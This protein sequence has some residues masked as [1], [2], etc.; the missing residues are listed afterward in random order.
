MVKALG[1]RDL[2]GKLVLPRLLY[3]VV[4]HAADRTARRS[5]SFLALRPARRISEFFRTLH[6]YR[7]NSEITFAGA[8]ALGALL[9]A[10]AL[11]LLAIALLAFSLSRL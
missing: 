5:F 7:E 3:A 2:R 1:L 11:L 9:H 10:S 8:H 6:E 4:V